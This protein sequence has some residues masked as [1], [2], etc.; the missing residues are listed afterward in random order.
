MS[1]KNLIKSF[2]LSQKY[3]FEFFFYEWDKKIFKVAMTKAGLPHGQGK[4]GNHE[5]SRKTKKN[6]KGRKSQ[7][8]MGV[9]EKS[10]EKLG[11]VF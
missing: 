10:L 4:S 11:K 2:M 5:K 7:V 8:K 6:A 3:S 1:F 9:F